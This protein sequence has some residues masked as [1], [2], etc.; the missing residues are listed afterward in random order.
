[1]SRVSDIPAC[2]TVIHF[3]V[4]HAG[5]QTR[6][7]AMPSLMA[8][9]WVG[10]NSGTVFLRLWTKVH[11]IKTACAEV[12]VV[13]NVVFR[14]TISCC[15]PEIFAIKSRS[16]AKSRRN[17]GVLGQP[18]FGGGSEGR[19]HPNFWPNFINLCHHQTFGEVL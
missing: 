14:L 18:N 1:M 17:F 19:G 4:N 8:A 3:V 5:K 16:C 7:V 2:K 11:R 15:I 6:Y 9:R 10:Q 13:C 12:S